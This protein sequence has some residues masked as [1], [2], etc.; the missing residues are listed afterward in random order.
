[1]SKFIDVA[2]QKFGRLVVV[3]RVEN[4]K[5]GQAMWKC[6]CE[7]GNECVVAGTY[8]RKGL[9]KSCGCLWYDAIKQA[10]STHGEY[11]TRLRSIWTGIKNR[12]YNKNEP[13]Y[14]YYGGKGVS[15]CGE[16]FEDFLA[17]KSWAIH[18]GYSEDLTIDRIDVDGDYCP[19]N[20]RWVSMK[21][22]CNNRTNNVLIELNGET[23]TL[24]EWV[25]LSPLSYKQVWHRYHVLG[26]DIEKSL[27]T[28][29]KEGA[30]NV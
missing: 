29:I 30:K 27:Y 20:C 19:E 28:P 9:T 18:N 11:H 24:A 25:E 21:K 22:Q 6:R 7:C 13:A 14:R 4:D 5:K 10:N 2:G 17:F 12:C 16:W 15:M 23:K 3:E 26:W 1:M 8:L